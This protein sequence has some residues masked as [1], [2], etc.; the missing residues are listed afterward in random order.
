MYRSHD[1]GEGPMA[2]A[3]QV[4]V[5]VRSVTDEEVDHFKRNGW[6]KLPHGSRWTR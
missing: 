1:P 2:T 4:H 3:E 6:V 5:D